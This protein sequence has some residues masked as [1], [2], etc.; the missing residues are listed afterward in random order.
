MKGKSWQSF[1]PLGPWLVTPD[2]IP[3]VQSL[4]IWL[5]VNGQKLQ[6]SSTSEMIV[7]A[8]GLVSYISRFMPLYPGDV[9][10]TGTPAGV[11]MG[12]SPPRYLKS[13]DKVVA[14]IEGLGEQRHV[15]R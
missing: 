13:G 12:F 9:I 6:D 3:D 5:S 1:A 11:G 2:E 7:G 15:C 4:P 10:A 14:G 8:V